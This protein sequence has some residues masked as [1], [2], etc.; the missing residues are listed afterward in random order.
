M[1]N[2]IAAYWIIMKDNWL[3]VLV[4]FSIVFLPSLIFY[5]FFISKNECERTVQ[6]YYFLSKSNPTAEALSVSENT[7]NA[8]CEAEGKK[9]KAYLRLFDAMNQPR[10]AP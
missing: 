3:K 5:R 2:L 8:A 1:T 7:M 4:I 6:E 10:K 9:A